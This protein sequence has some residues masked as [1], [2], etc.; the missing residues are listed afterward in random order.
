MK[1]RASLLVIITVLA[2]LHIPAAAATVPMTINLT[3]TWTTITSA[4]TANA[5]A[6]SVS[7]GIFN[8][9]RITMK[10]I[11]QQG[12]LLRATVTCAPP[13]GAGATDTL[14]G[15]IVGNMVH[16][17]GGGVLVTGEFFGDSGTQKMLFR[18]QTVGEDNAGGGD[19]G[20]GLMKRTGP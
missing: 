20:K 16:F 11:D 7:K 14:T 5:R 10:I 6:Y 17:S 3:G 15:A 18:W 8:N 13:Y 19:T 2:A 1:K 9:V 12:D 4:T